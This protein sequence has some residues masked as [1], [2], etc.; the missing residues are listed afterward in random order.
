MEEEYSRVSTMPDS[1]LPAMPDSGL[2]AM[3]DSGFALRS[4]SEEQVK[5]IHQGVLHILEKIGLKVQSHLAAELFTDA[6]A[7]VINEQ[8]FFRVNLPRWLVENCIG[9]AP[10]SFVY[11]GRDPKYDFTAGPRRTGF[12]AFGQCVKILDPETGEHR[13]SIKADMAGSARVQDALEN[14]R[15]VTRT[16]AP[17][18]M[19]ADS[20]AL[21]CLDAILR[22]T[23][24][25]ISGGAGN[26][27]NLKAML[28]LLYA[29]A[30]SREKF[31]ARPFYSPSFCPTSPLTLCEDCCD[32]AIE[33]ARA[34]LGL[35][36]MI[37][38][39]SGAT[40]PATLT[41]T[42]T[43]GIA[44]QIAGLTLAQLANR[45]TPVTLGSATTIMDLRT[46]VSAM[47]APES[48]I[49]NA[50]M[51]QMAN[52][53]GLPSRVACG[54]S[55]A[56]ILDPQVGYEY[57][58]NA[59]TAA[60]SGA[61]IVFG[62]GAMESGL[63][64]SPAKLLMDHECM[65]NIRKILN[66]IS[67]DEENSDLDII[68]EIGPSGSFLMHRQT[69][70]H[71]RELRKNPPNDLFNRKSRAAWEKERGGRSIAEI[72]AEKACHRINNH[73]PAALPDGAV[74]KM[75]KI[76]ASF[77]VPQSE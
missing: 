8:G 21:H 49:I 70:Q 30:G 66:G 54:V 40:A 50:S 41:G 24:K 34:G 15:I 69:L 51:V 1:S 68:E 75:D 26:V 42:I 32:V 48:G 19:P 38:P 65:G 71:V 62:G 16:M 39:L 44:E 6:G 7:K 67:T 37:M 46:T 2:P 35:V 11:Y 17:G 57:A 55:D 25:H 56:N 72:A 28:E 5:S 27:L 73:T 23:G 60:L 14:I 52:F 47:G 64:H 43:L 61:S 36:V 29:A 74:E 63:T 53:Y 59:V 22:N 9:S 13:S 18:D 31:E 33:A 10:K 12:A 58:T 4:F 3:P 45:G 76:L 77:I 20:Q